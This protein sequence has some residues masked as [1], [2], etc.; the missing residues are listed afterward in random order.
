M[1]CKYLELERARMRGVLQLELFGYGL[2]GHVMSSA[3]G[4]GRQG[5]TFSATHRRPV[6]SFHLPFQ[7]LTLAS[8]RLHHYGSAEE[9]KIF[10]R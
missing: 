10:K 9:D 7:L 6:F 3:P 1:Y 2:H 5:G 8:H 4:D